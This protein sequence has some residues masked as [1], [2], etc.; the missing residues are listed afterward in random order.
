MTLAGGCAF[1]AH[2]GEWKAGMHDQRIE[3]V[4]IEIGRYLHAHPDAADSAEGVRHWWLTEG[5]A[6]VALAIVYAALD[7]LVSQGAVKMRVL[8]D[9]TRIYSGRIGG[10]M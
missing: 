4:A 3:E 8:A 7:K 9:G 1:Q 6:K 10:S 2:S 5:S